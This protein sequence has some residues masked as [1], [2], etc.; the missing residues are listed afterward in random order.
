MGKV[1]VDDT[2][3]RVQGAD[4]PRGTKVKVIGVEGVILKIKTVESAE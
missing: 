4:L 2:W 3:W 1:R